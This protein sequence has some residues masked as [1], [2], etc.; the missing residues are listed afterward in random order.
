MIM[1][2]RDTVADCRSLLY[3]F[4]IPESQRLCGGLNFVWTSGFF[5]CATTAR[6]SWY[7]IIRFISAVHDPCYSAANAKERECFRGLGHI[8][9]P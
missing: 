1:H 8:R 2:L 9:C 7:E 3:V 5:H 4:I 6:M